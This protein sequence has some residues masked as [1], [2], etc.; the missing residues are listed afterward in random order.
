MNVKLIITYD[1]AHISSCTESVKK[2]MDTIGAKPTFLKSKYHGIFLIDVS[3]PKE[4]VKKL[5]ALSK[6]NK[7]LF[8]KTYR[9]I[10]VDKWVSSRVTDMAKA[11]KSLVPKIGLNEKWKMDLE[12]RYYHKFDYNELILK[13]TEVV[14]RE[15]IDL[16][17]P[18]K[19][20]KVEIVG[21]SAA[22]TLLEPDEL[23][24][25]S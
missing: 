15:K 5:K 4:V 20:I 10:P 1:P 14:N 16:K 11:I 23:L 3:K 12:K 2:L 13:L 25:I 6:K 18:Q 8:G 9:Y 24:L 21:S 19:I 22:I 17:K 7:E